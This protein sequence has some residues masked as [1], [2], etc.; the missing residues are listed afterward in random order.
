MLPT[1]LEGFA[2]YFIPCY[3]KWSIYLTIKF[4][5]HDKEIG[6]VIC[7]DKSSGTFRLCE[8][9]HLVRPLSMLDFMLYQ[10]D[11]LG[12]R[13]NLNEDFCKVL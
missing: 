10:G 1:F 4:V 11:K 8:Y 12:L 9:E 6:N 3:N 7:T 2:E 13:F 5:I